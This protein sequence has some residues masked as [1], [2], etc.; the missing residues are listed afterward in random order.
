VVK[1]E[2]STPTFKVI[3]RGKEGGGKWK[4]GTIKKEKWKDKEIR[5]LVGWTLKGEWLCMCTCLYMHICGGGALYVCVEWMMMR[6]GNVIEQ[7]DIHRRLEHDNNDHS[8]VAPTLSMIYPFL[9]F[10]LLLLFTSLLN[11]VLG[12]RIGEY[13]QSQR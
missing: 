11:L 7:G 13:R 2:G 1:F 5:I 12:E 9:S 3:L 8:W 10:T 6:R 4:S